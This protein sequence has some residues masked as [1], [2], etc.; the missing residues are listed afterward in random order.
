M[1]YL[2]GGDDRKGVHDSVG[3]LF[4]DFG[5]EKSSHTGASSATERVSQLESLKA[6]ARFG[7]FSDNVENGV[8]ELGSFCVV[9]LGP[10]VS[11][12]RL[13]EYEVIWA[14]DL[15]EWTRSDRVHRS[16]LEIDEDGA[17]NIS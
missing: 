12:A 9:T 3:V 11:G 2:G 1:K 4:S 17:G 15:A 7:F 10:V 14:E 6:I 8:D 13:A 16:R 5:D